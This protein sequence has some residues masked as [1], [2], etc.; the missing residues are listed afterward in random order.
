MKDDSGYWKKYFPSNSLAVPPILAK[1]V[2]GGWGVDTISRWQ[3][4]GLYMSFKRL[5]G[6]CDI[7]EDPTAEI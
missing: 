1:L 2:H 6:A 7:W 3:G 5:E 4:E